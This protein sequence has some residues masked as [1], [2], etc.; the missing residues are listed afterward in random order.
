MELYDVYTR[1][2]V[3]T[4]ETR[5]RGEAVP[6]GFCRLIV[7]I[8]IFN[9]AGEMLIQQRQPFKRGWSN[10]WDVSVG[11]NAVAGDTSQS[12]A[13]RE[14]REELGLTLDLTDVMPACTVYFEDGFD[15]FYTVTQDIALEDIRM[16]PEEVQQVKWA[17][18]EEILS[19]IDGGLFI[20]YEKSLI[21]FLFFLRQH[22]E[23][24]TRAD[25]SPLR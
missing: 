2:R 17:T 12:A 23:T 4:G 25:R 11:G 24:H 7:H 18:R 21:D 15:D 14:V 8:C 22:R 5:V 6:A 10:L 19:L 1:D 9:R 20:P 13:M 16:Q 3:K